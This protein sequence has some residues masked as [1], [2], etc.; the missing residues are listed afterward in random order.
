MSKNKTKGVLPPQSS[1]YFADTAQYKRLS[2]IVR[3]TETAQQAA[4]KIGI[5]K[6]TLYRWLKYGIP[7]RA[8]NDKQKQSKITRVSA[9]F[10]T[11]R[12]STPTEQ[13][14]EY[15]P[16]SYVRKH[17]RSNTK[18]WNV[19][20]ASYEQILY[21][22]LKECETQ[23]YNGA[24][25][26]IKFNV[27]F[28]GYFDGENGDYYDADGNGNLTAKNGKKLDSY[29]KRKKVRDTTSWVSQITAE[30]PFL[31]TK[32]LD[33][34]TGRCDSGKLNDY[35]DNFYNMRH[36]EIIEVRFNDKTFTDNFYE[37]PF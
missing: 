17:A 11:Y 1:K 12:K 20:N 7:N 33:L 3:N 31:N 13:Q 36:F 22:M 30:Q 37:L 16:F 15:R 19:E 5:S 29:E 4:Q 25:F 18:H 2:N 10:D 6:T 26:L 14:K 34:T 24:Y 23:R 8:L 21:I 35:L 9:G 28:T 27:Y 32:I